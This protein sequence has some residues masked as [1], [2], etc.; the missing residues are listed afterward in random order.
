MYR[1][2]D[3]DDSQANSSVCF[4]ISY[5]YIYTLKNMFHVLCWIWVMGWVPTWAD[6]IDPTMEINFVLF[7]LFLFY[8]K[9]MLFFSTTKHFVIMKLG[10]EL[11]ILPL[12][13]YPIFFK[14]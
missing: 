11:G 3:A 1:L 5:M 8:V 12:P 4:T 2:E 10:F 13:E 14:L 9:K 6:L 7:I